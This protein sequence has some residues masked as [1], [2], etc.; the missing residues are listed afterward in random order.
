MAADP[1][2]DGD[3]NKLVSNDELSSKSDEK[4]LIS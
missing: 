1:G 4:M 2:E 3:V